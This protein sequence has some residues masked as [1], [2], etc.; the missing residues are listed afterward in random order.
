M[1]SNI[2]RIRVYR[3]EKS[4]KIAAIYADRRFEGYTVL[5]LS[6]D[7]RSIVQVRQPK[8]IKQ[9]T[10]NPT[11][12]QV[13]F[14][15]TEIGQKDE[16][17]ASTYQLIR[18]LSPEDTN[19]ERWISTESLDDL[20]V[21]PE[22]ELTTEERAWAGERP[23]N[24]GYGLA[25]TLV[26]VGLIAFAIKVVEG[27]T[28][29]FFSF[30]ALVAVIFLIKHRWKL[31]KRPAPQ[32]LEELRAYKKSMKLEAQR[33]Y[34]SVKTKFGKALEEYTNW[35]VLTPR[36]FE[37]AVALKLEQDGFKVQTT[38]YSNDGGVDIEGADPNG[39]STIMQAKQYKRPVGISVVREMIGV[40]SSRSDNPRT[41]IYSLVG[42]TRGA[43]QLAKLE[44]IELRAVRSDLLARISQ[45]AVKGAFSQ[46]VRFPP[47]NS[48]SSR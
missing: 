23:G 44:G 17:I 10:F 13:E 36:Q 40:R 22:E 21:S 19:L 45:C 30:V 25:L 7:M 47:G 5:E 3:Y 20:P 1:S 2:K 18:V 24:L 39:H 6:P 41:I 35:E 4:G 38:K 33:N 43:K 16:L 32:K 42:F 12:Y 37:T 15:K 26:T 34:V 9:N 46:W 27:N 48:R 28:Q 8:Y 31:P 11:K 14:L 29:Y